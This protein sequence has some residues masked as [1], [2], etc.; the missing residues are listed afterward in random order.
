LRA[1][2]IA[3][4]ALLLAF[5]AC[6]QDMHDQPRYEPLERSAFFPDQR[7]A[8]PLVAGT[9]AQ[10]DLREDD[11]L[12]TGKI[13]GA[14]ATAFPFQIARPDLERGRER[15]NI[16]CAPCHGR[17]GDGRGIV[18]QRGF[19][20]PP[21]FHDPRLRAAPTG[22]FFDVITRGYGAMA[23]YAFR[24][25]VRDRWLIAAYLR[26]L[27]FSQNASLADVEAARRQELR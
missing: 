7:S 9:V 25:P 12:Y 27:Q 26:A 20:Q 22:H 13:N 19:K 15:Y 11:H 18:V 10:G 21:S 4:A 1:S 8:R 2:P 17:L 24:V 6:R 3:A 14:L 23:D 16:F 5:T